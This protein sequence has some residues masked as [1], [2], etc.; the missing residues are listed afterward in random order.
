MIAF[1][2][3]LYNSIAGSL[4]NRKDEGFS[5]RKMTAVAVNICF[6][7]THVFW[8]KHA[9]TKEDFEYLIPVLTIEALYVLLLLGII[10]MQEVIKLKNGSKTETAA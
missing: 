10:T 9:Y 7:T 2:K 3:K 8:W 6:I 4:N 5:A 1:L